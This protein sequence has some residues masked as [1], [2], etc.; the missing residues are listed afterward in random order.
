MRMIPGNVKLEAKVLPTAIVISTLM[1]LMVGVL[2]SLWE[3]DFMFFTRI[4]RLRENRANIESAYTLYKNHPEILY[5]ADSDTTWKL[6]EQESSIVTMKRSLW[7]LY[8]WVSVSN[9]SVH[10]SRLLGSES[11]TSYTFY[12]ADNRSPLT[13]AGETH[14]RGK[15]ALPAHGL[16]YGTLGSVFFS[17]EELLP[18]RMLQSDGALPSPSPA[19]SS[20]ANIRNLFGLEGGERLPADSI[21]IS[22]NDPSALMF[23]VEQDLPPHTSLSGRI[24]LVADHVRIDSSCRLNN[25]ILVG[26]SIRIGK[27]FRGRAQFFATDSI[28]LD[29]G[30]TLEEPSGVYAEKYLE[31]GADSRINGYAIISPQERIA[32]SRLNYK[33]SRSSKIRG[34]LYCDGVSQ[35]QGIVSGSAY[36]RQAA[37]FSKEG[38]YRDIIY[39]ASILE[40][41]Y[42]PFPIWLSEQARRKEALCL[43]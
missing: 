2:M 31:I 15:A 40:N 9:G 13:I 16:I 4:S 8:D 11:D 38:Y 32:F 5:S 19:P 14:L 7:G 6:Y 12:Y 37:Y 28:L 43:P 20:L 36:I 26:Q 17:G 24:I 23:R 1:L 21:F 3:F 18:E 10:Q 27:N 41:F 29:Q 42:T 33:Q 25:I 34:M 39:D 30:V 22:F 35:I